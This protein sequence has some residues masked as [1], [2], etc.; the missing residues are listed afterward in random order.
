[1]TKVVTLLNQK[2]GVG[3]STGTINL[4]AVRAEKLAAANA[5]PNAPSRVAAVSIDPQG[6]A[7]WWANR[8]EELPFHLIQAHDDPLDWLAQLN[9]LPGIDEVYVDTPGWFDLD[10]DSAGDGL[11]DGY[12]AEALRVVLD[13]TDEVLVPMLTQPMCFDPTARTIGKILEPR[14]LPIVYLLTI[15]TH[16]MARSGWRRPRSSC[17]GAATRSRRPRYVTT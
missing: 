10:P 2:G 12:S 4:A 7:L 5:D 13:V 15:G 3:K 8:V 9:T 1:M 16:A 17:T 11:G 14:A 6:S